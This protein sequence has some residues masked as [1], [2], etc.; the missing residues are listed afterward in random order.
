MNDYWF[1]IINP[2]SGNGKSKK[3][4]SKIINTLNKE[5]INF[6]YAITKYANHEF[7]ITQEQIK[8]GVKSTI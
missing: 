5:K 4:I 8:K 1:V 3:Y 2:T 6:Q 7:E